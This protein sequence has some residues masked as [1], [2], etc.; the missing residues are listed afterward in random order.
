MQELYQ[1]QMLGL[2]AQMRQQGLISNPDMVAEVRNP[3]CGD[4]VKAAI[5]LSEGA[6][7]SA[8]IDARGCALCEAGS[9]LWLS[10]CHKHTLT[11]LEQLKAAFEHWLIS[12]EYQADEHPNFS[13][14][15]PV[16]HIKNRH[17]CVL[18]AF[19]TAARFTPVLR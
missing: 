2:A 1:K 17:K 8:S 11:E 18:L 15:E 5:T 14:F 3:V 4:R 10:L 7:T 12:G 6:I 19:D 16:R 9:G 13:A